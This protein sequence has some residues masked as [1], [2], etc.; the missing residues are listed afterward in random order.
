MFQNNVSKKFPSTYTVS[1]VI[2]TRN[3]ANHLYSCLQGMAR[4][5]VKPHEIIIVNNGLPATIL[6]TIR[7][8]PKLP[9]RVTRLKNPSY[10][11]TRNRGIEMARGDIIALIDDDCIASPSWIQKIIHTH[12]QGV[13]VAQGVGF[14]DA[15][16]SNLYTILHNLR[17]REGYMNALSRAKGSLKIS[18]ASLPLISMIDNKNVSFPKKLLNLFPQWYAQW[19]PSYICADDFELANRLNDLN[20]PI[21]YNRNIIVY[22]SGRN[23]LMSYIRRNFEYG[24]SDW[25][26]SRL[27]RYRWK[28]VEVVLGKL[29]GWRVQAAI[30]SWVITVRTHKT[31]IAYL[32]NIQEL[33]L[34]IKLF[35]F[36]LYVVVKFV[37]FG[38]YLYEGLF[39]YGTGNGSKHGA[40][41]PAGS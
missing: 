40:T 15:Q 5:T 8:F 2:P 3:R 33:T 12:A 9:I 6:P 27:N 20:V 25:W 17:S 28:K 36:I 1:V 31:L 22:H 30:H 24:R 26:I 41:Y 23:S 29:L 13:F 16:Q 18:S 39:L 37:R 4:Q 10:S 11:G 35:G 32:F 19:L 7:S 14:Y 21:V 34:P 38:G